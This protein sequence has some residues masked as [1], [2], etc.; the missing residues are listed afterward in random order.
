MKAP[1]GSSTNIY[2]NGRF[3][4]TFNISLDG[5]RSMDESPKEFHGSAMPIEWR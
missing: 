2:R 4:D 5:T 1:T 3:I